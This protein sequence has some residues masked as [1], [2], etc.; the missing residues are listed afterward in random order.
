VTEL[1]MTGLS[2]QERIAK[3][4][5]LQAKLEAE[6]ARL[7]RDL[8][9]VHR[10]MLQTMGMPALVMQDPKNTAYKYKYSYSECLQV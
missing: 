2:Q 4:L 6:Q 10:D 8:T 1:Q 7:A 9:W 5:E 3:Q